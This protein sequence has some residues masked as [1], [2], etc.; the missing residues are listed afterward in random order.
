MM[1]KNYIVHLKE[2]V[3]MGNVAREHDEAT[4]MQILKK[5]LITNIKIIIEGFY[6][7]TP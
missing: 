1:R 3:Q 5:L 2:V 7:S 4:Y 6:G